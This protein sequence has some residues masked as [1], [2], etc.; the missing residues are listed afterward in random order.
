ME[1][2]VISI[3]DLSGGES[4]YESFALIVVGVNAGIIRVRRFDQPEAQAQAL[5]GI[6]TRPRVTELRSDVGGD[7]HATD[8]T[9]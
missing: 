7:A 4:T 8:R 6:E 2:I 9:L 5:Y 1:Q 3:E